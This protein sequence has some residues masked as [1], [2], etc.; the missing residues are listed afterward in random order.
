MEQL[1]CKPGRFLPLIICLSLSNSIDGVATSL[2]F[3]GGIAN[4]NAYIYA[5]N[6]DS[7]D[8]IP[9][10]QILF[11]NILLCPLYSLIAFEEL[12]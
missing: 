5:Y 6:Y 4:G 3:K 8:R 11:N 7:L 12:G 10:C 9:C 1:K 2:Y